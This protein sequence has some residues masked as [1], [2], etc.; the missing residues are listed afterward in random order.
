MRNVEKVA[1]FGNKTSNFSG[2]KSTIE[3]LEPLLAEITE[4]KT[5]S[6]KKSK[7]LRLFDMVKG[8]FKDGL[9]A[10]IIIIDVYSTTAFLYAEILGF[11]S[12]VYKKRYVLVLHGGNLPFVYPKRKSR[13]K[14]L[15]NS[16]KYVVAPSYYLKNF[17][18]GEGFKIQLIPNIIELE[19]Y[20]YL[21]RKKIRP[22]ILG[23]RGFKSAYNP[24]MTLEAV[25]ILRDRGIFVE[26][27]LLGNQDEEHYQEVIVYIKTYELD[28]RIKL[29]P[30]QEKLVW[31]EESQNFD[32]MVSNPL[33]DNT[34]V[35]I[36]EGMAL[37]MCVIT[38]NVGGVPD[39]VTDHQ[40]VLYVESENST[41]LANKISKLLADKN[42]ANTLSK[43]ARKKAEQFDWNTVKPLWKKLL[44][45]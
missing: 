40:E 2:T 12:R 16:A 17:F 28:D 45:E 35:S 3:T 13:F 42:L 43:S 10:D 27:T 29:R 22:R 1:Y 7:L 6:D 23:I 41:D 37:G 26:L 4:I 9:G 24:L 25:K 31:I 33:I 36:I 18:D 39:L 32:I 30:K 15:F 38:T 11:L 8:F 5:Y 21:E 34:P 19:Q 14:V 20:P 44:V